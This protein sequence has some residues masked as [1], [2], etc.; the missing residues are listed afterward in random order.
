MADSSAEE[1]TE[2]PTPRRIQEARRT[3]QT[4]ISRDLAAAL[5]VA[6]ACV[7]F[8]ATASAGVG[9]LLQAMR[10]TMV[11]ASKSTA[12]A[13]A[14]KS[15]LE[16][17]ALTLALPMGALLAVA[18][19]AGVV[20]TRGLATVRP[21]R[22]EARRVLPSL[23]RVLG[24]DRVIEAGKGVIGLAV[25]FIVAF[26]SIHPVISSIAA[27]SGASA[28]QIL[29]AIGVLGERLA[30]HL[31]MALLALGTADFLWQRHRRGKALRM[32]RDE[33]KREHRESEGEPA[34]KAERF[35]LHQE[36]MHEQTIGDVNG[37]DFVV[38]HAG[39]MAVAIRYDRASASAPVV[40]VKGEHR[41]AQAI[42]VAARADGVPVFVDPE[43]A[44]ALA[45][46]EHG[47]EI[48]EALYERV[49]G[50]LVQVQA[51]GQPEN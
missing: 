34:H 39:L 51:K 28:V 29:R 17:V 32:S 36:F 45:L 44:R 42:E 11:G 38:V 13:A 30:I 19:L 24:C 31:T 4:P 2:S 37:A 47:G 26:W 3:G 10:E 50:C 25:L 7:V 41:H 18:C 1:R 33:V 15:G 6:T 48:P 12:M 5:V 46:V 40:M 8:V 20:Q 35:R 14:A 43:L 23:D 22:P 9:G 27:L 16:V 49:A 21:L